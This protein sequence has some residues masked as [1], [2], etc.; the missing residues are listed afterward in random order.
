MSENE[1]AVGIWAV[2]CIDS[3]EIIAEY[4]QAWPAHLKQAELG[5]DYEVRLQQPK[6]RR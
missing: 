4:D 5:D 3:G 2:F 1:D 6:I